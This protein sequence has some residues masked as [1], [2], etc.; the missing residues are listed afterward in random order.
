M[1]LK[2]DKQQNVDVKTNTNQKVE[3][4][5][6]KRFFFFVP[7]LL[8]F[9]SIICGMWALYGVFTGQNV[10]L[11][12][13][14]IIIA[15]FFDAMDGRFARFFGV[16]GVF[17]VELDSLADFFS[18]GIA[19]T[20]VFFSYL[21]SNYNIQNQQIIFAILMLFPICMASRLAR[22]NIMT[23]DNKEPIE[24][25]NFKKKFFYGM[26]APAGSIALM[27]PIIIDSMV[28]GQLFSCYCI[29]VA[30]A[31]LIA[32]LLISPF[33]M[34]SPK[35]ICIGYKTPKEIIHTIIVL[36]SIIAFVIKPIECVL[37]VSLLYVINIPIAMIRYKIG[38]SRI[39]K[40]LLSKK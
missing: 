40:T 29:P 24:I 11:S 7:N 30:Y 5:S 15:G 12:I 17:G 9:C 6:W 35:S 28:Q 33:P 38:I 27:L 37:F 8:T 31:L 4:Q 39:E 21:I 10:F 13:F 32:F 23:L 25:K 3:V 16:S 22:F 36:L 2:S 26:P 14:L 1:V 20:F 19:T 18:F 34:P